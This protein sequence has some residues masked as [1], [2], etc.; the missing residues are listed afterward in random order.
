MF[1]R[2]FE[3]YVESPLL[4]QGYKS[5]YLDCETHSFVYPLGEPREYLD[6]SIRRLMGFS[7]PYIINSI[8]GVGKYG[9]HHS[10]RSI[11][12]NKCLSKR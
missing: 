4:N 11:S 8:Q 9:L 3:A 7:V 10:K 2:A 6:R 5:N 1:A 12:F